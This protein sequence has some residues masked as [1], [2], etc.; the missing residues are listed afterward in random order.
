MK[1]RFPTPDRHEPGDLASSDD[2]EGFS[3]FTRQLQ[4]WLLAACAIGG[5]GVL[6]QDDQRALRLSAVAIFAILILAS[7]FMLRFGT[8]T[9][10]KFLVSLFWLVNGAYIFM[11]SGVYSAQVL[12]YP[13]LASMC[14][15]ILGRSWLLGLTSLS[16]AF[17]LVL[18]YADHIGIYTPT[19]R[20]GPMLVSAVGTAV[21]VI[22]AILSH[23]ILRAHSESQARLKDEKRKL[24]KSQDELL[25]LL[26]FDP[27]TGLRSRY[28]LDED[29]DGLI[30]EARAFA[31]LT[32]AL[33]SVGMINHNFGPSTGNEAIA[34]A[35]RIIQASLPAAC[36]GYRLSGSRLGLLY[37][38]QHDD[39]DLEALA[40]QLHA[41]MK[42]NL[43]VQKVDIYIDLAI[44]V[45]RYPDH[46]QDIESLFRNA[47]IAGDHAEQVE[48]A[49]LSF[50]SPDLRDRG[51]RLHWLDINLRRALDENQFRLVYQPKVLMATGGL[52][53]FEALLRWK[54]PE[55]GEIS[56]AEFVQ[57]CETNGL[58]NS[59]GRWVIQQAAHQL[60][61]WVA[62]GRA[63]RVSVN[64]SA[65]QLADPSLL[66]CLREA[67]GLAGGYLDVELTESFLSESEERLESFLFQCRDMG[68]GI[69]LDDFG[70][71]YSS[72]SRLA[73]MPL[74]AL[75]IDR[76]FVSRIGGDA[77]NAAVL[78]SI[79]GVAHDLRLDLIAEGAE[80]AEQIDYLKALGV[81]H[82][83]GWFYS[84]ALEADEI[85][86]LLSGHQF[87]PR[88]GDMKPG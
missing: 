34:G 58:I 40:R 42:R 49:N 81:Q 14:G 15:W 57:R 61:L 73:T 13:F 59:L 27:L 86:K 9:A 3:R 23:T 8:A 1:W 87:G 21:F 38:G 68:F 46:G 24:E 79:V 82:A 78:R 45:A 19:P 72:F 85:A 6:L 80:T 29:V 66:G 71:G 70:T 31:L 74:T 18:G 56:P 88:G 75:K 62:A 55:Q 11:F 54:H 5:V 43:P 84:K 2:Q 41:V 26:H 47:M 51:A 50:Y 10:T 76:S 20:S 60:S 16:V 4:N 39:Q 67:Q 83:Q 28:A 25:R 63:V 33:K 53:A 32:V 44:G 12:I 30:R 7:R 17:I 48:N 64:V 36:T 52:H 22:M 65:R 35:A 77:R 37:L 69:H